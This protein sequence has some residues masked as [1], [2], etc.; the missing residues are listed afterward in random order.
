MQELDVQVAIANNVRVAVGAMNDLPQTN[1]LRSTRKVLLSAVVGSGDL[2][3][4]PSV[5]AAASFL[6]VDKRAIRDAKR[7]REEGRVELASLQPRCKRSDAV[8][9]DPAKLRALHAFWVLHTVESSSVKDVMTVDGQR[10][11]KRFMTGSIDD[12]VR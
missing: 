12:Y 11:M 5:K 3:Q 10:C 2:K 7:R 9:S 8:E 6:G 1:S 4:Q